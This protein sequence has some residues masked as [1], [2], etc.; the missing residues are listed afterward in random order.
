MNPLSKKIRACHNPDIEPKNTDM[1]YIG[2]NEEKLKSSKNILYRSKKIGLDDVCHIGCSGYYNFDV[3]YW[4]KSDY[5]IIFDI[6]PKQIKF[7]KHTLLILKSSS[8]RRKFVDNCISYMDKIYDVTYQE[9]IIF[10]PNIS[11]DPSYAKIKI[12]QNNHLDLRDEVIQIIY[13][14]TRSGSWLS[15]DVSYE[16]IRKLAIADNIAIFC[17]DIKSTNIFKYIG[18][19]L[20]TNHIMIDTLYVSN[21]HDYVTD[22]KLFNQSVVFITTLSTLIIK[23]NTNFNLNQLII[24]GEEFIR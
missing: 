3:A 19:L 18:E 24:T 7:M 10:S 16:Y 9:E 13:E 20:K 5:I 2:T 6:N 8:D 11:N 23:T 14:L 22:N 12:A 1:V 15:T 17:E 21:I 4:R